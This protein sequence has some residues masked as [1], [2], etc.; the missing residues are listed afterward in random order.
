[1]SVLIRP[2]VFA[3]LAALQPVMHRRT[4]RAMAMQLARSASFTLAS[5]QG[6]ILA[7]GGIYPDADRGWRECW[8]LAIANPPARPLLEG[9]RLIV[10]HAG[11]G[12]PLVCFVDASNRRHV[13]YAEAL[14]FEAAETLSSAHASP[15]SLPAV[16]LRM[17]IREAAGR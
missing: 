3:D 7:T 1:M 6:R 17:Q 8:M 5:G 10:D 9:V 16:I 13:R 11:P 4:A 12:W 15:S 14:G 2:A